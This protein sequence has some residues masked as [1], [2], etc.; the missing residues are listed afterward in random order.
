[1]YLCALVGHLHLNR[2]SVTWRWCFVNPIFKEQPGKDLPQTVPTGLTRGTWLLIL[3]L[4]IPQEDDWIWTV[5]S[6]F[7]EPSS[8]QTFCMANNC[9][10]P[11]LRSACQWNVTNRDA[12]GIYLKTCSKVLK[13]NKNREFLSWLS[14]NKSDSP[15]GCRFDPWPRSVG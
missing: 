11:N 10:N 1:M 9:E 6:R 2:V 8:F 12:I 4:F 3:G 7:L 13:E 15:W 14:R 5:D